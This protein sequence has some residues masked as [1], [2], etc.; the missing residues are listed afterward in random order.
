M[1]LPAEIGLLPW[2]ALRRFEWYGGFSL[3][4]TLVWMYTEVLR[5]LMSFVRGRED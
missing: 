3:M 4:V 5:L 2:L 1:L